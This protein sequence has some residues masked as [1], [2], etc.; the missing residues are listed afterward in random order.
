MR[1]GL[2]AP[3]VSHRQLSFADHSSVPL[4][5]AH[6][7]AERRPRGFIFRSPESSTPRAGGIFHQTLGWTAVP[8]KSNRVGGSTG[9]TG[10]V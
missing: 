8:A 1:E 6:G 3:S 2:A 7:G 9:K 4:D 10:G 5:L